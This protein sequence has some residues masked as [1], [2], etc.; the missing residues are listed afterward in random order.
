LRE[1]ACQRFAFGLLGSR[2]CHLPFE[3]FCL[4]NA[5]ALFLFDDLCDALPSA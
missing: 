2:F 5:L 4:R 3:G 1:Y